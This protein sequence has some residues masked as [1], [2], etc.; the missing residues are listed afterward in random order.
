MSEENVGIARRAIEINRS[1][2]LAVAIEGLIGLSARVALS[3][4]LARRA[5]AS[6][7]TS[8]A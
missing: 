4:L 6:A 7:Y 5:Y 2:D 1:G 8:S 3:R